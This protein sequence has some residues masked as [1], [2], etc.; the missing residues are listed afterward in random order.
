MAIGGSVLVRGGIAAPRSRRI[1]GSVRVGG[2]LLSRG[3]G[4]R[5]RTVVVHQDGTVYPQGWLAD[6]VHGPITWQPSTEDR[7]SLSVPVGQGG[8]LFGNPNDTDDWGIEEPYREVQLWRGNRLLTWG[9]TIGHRVAG[10]V[11]EASGAGAGWYLGRKIGP[12]ARPNLLDVDDAD[13]L[14]GWWRFCTGYAF[15]T[16]PLVAPANVD[17]ATAPDTGWAGATMRFTSTLAA[18]PA[19]DFIDPVAVRFI[20]IN[21]A[22]FAHTYTFSAWRWFEDFDRPNLRKAGLGLAVLDVDWSNLYSDVR[23]AS[24]ENLS[25]QRSTTPERARV[26]IEVPA[27]G[28]DLILACIITAPRGITHY[29]RPD[30]DCDVGLEFA[31]EDQA[32]IAFKTV[33][34]ATGNAAS[35]YTFATKHPLWPWA[36]GEI[37]KSDVNIDTHCPRTGVHRD[38]RF[39]FPSNMTGKAGVDTFRDLDDGLEW[40]FAYNAAAG[41][42]TFCT[43]FPRL[44]RY[45]GSCPFRLTPA[46]ATVAAV[47]WSIEGDQGANAIHVLTAG[48]SR[49]T[50]TAIDTSDFADGL[51]LDQV[52]TAPVDIADDDLATYAEQRRQRTRR[53]ITLACKLPADPYWTDRGLEAGDRVPVTVIHGDLRVV[54][55]MRIERLTLTPDDHLEVLLSPW[56]WGAT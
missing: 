38:R 17:E 37:G 42:R 5:R 39:L 12:G 19:V 4:T 8:A 1:G 3:N 16:G 52:L 15:T 6:A 9:P 31:G 33:D 28:V 25:D 41:T 40:D 44:G 50:A 13:P 7:W 22:A 30:L 51:T 45:R 43:H 55:V 26:S 24:W 2:E 46:G 54:G 47:A 34:H 27:S 18:G 56:P 21:A 49:A 14:G 11:L 10:D 32:D 35:T 20:R 53:P 23:W 36:G 29:W 48:E